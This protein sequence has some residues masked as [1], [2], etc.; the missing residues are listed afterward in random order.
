[1]DEE[2]RAR[3]GKLLRGDRAPAALAAVA[4][5][6]LGSAWILFS[7]QALMLVVEDPVRL[8]QL[9]TWKG[10]TFVAFSSLGVYGLLR[11]ALL[12]RRR[13]LRA[14]RERERFLTTLMKNLPGMAYRCEN[15]PAWTMHYMS[16]GV[17]PL[18]GYAAEEFLEG[19]IA[20]GEVI[21]PEDRERVWE[22]VQEAVG[23]GRRF[24][25]EYRIVGRGGRLKWVWEQGTPVCSPSGELEALE[26][27]VTDVTGL[28][29]AAATAAEAPLPE[30]RVGG[31]G[32]VAPIRGSETPPI[33]AS[34]G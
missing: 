18:T 26:G 34:A 10:L 21:H 3:I 8:T 16:F 20:W 27:F 25:V 2:L 14:L 22:E 24:R 33:A 32:T 15:D 4:Y 7:D 12:L 9:Q 31:A 11:G 28:K 30:S 19:R 23:N 5:A 1:M 29:R 17:G 6:V 13:S